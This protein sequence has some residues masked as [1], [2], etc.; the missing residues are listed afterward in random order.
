MSLED[1]FLDYSYS[2][3]DI[4][5]L[6]VKNEDDLNYMNSVSSAMLMSSNFTTRLMLWVGGAFIIWLKSNLERLNLC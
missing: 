6:R 1:K 2:K 4:K 3:K 5:K